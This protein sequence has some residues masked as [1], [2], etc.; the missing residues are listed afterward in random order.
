MTEEET[1]ELELLSMATS[2]TRK[3][4]VEVDYTG[5]GT[6]GQLAFERGIDHEWFTLVDLSTIEAVPGRMMRVFRLT[7]RGVLRLRDLR[8]MT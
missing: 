1:A 8:E 6:A 3:F 5:W 7:E 4:A 2:G